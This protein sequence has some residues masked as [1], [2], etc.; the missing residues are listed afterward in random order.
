MHSRGVPRIK[1]ASAPAARRTMSEHDPIRAYTPRSSGL[2]Y[3]V[4]VSR[5]SE[6]QVH[7]DECSRATDSCSRTA[8]FKQEQQ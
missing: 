2:P 8:L 7:D 6:R 1:R 4:V 5:T 3:F